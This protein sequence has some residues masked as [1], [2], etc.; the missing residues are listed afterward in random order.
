MAL[1]LPHYSPS[2]WRKTS[3]LSLSSAIL[4]I[5][6]RHALGEEEY[7]QEDVDKGV[8]GA[9]RGVVEVSSRELVRAEGGSKLDIIITTAG[10]A[11]V[12]LVVVADLAGRITTSHKGI[13]MHP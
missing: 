10:V 6:R 2:N 7:S 8:D 11:E 12:V 9:I 13:G 3:R 4:A 5:L 1:E